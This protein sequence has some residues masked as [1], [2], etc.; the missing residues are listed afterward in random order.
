M[1]TIEIKSKAIAAS[2][3][4]PHVSYL[5]TGRKKRASGKVAG[6]D[7]RTGLTWVKPDRADWKHVHV[8]DEEIAAGR[9]KPEYHRREKREDE[10]KAPRKARAPKAPPEP[11]WKTLVDRFHEQRHKSE[12]VSMEFATLLVEE[13]EAAYRQPTLNLQTP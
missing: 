4:D 8:T 6:I 5:R 3:M 11:R 1:T 2:L 7:S 10:P 12:P 9:Q 13:L